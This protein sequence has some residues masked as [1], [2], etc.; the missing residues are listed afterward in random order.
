MKNITFTILFALLYFITGE[1]SFTL[2]TTTSFE[3]LSIFIP[4][5]VALASIMLFGRKVVGG[6]FL[7]QVLLSLSSG[8]TFFTTVAIATTN[9]LEAFIAF[10]LIRRFK[11]KITPEDL[12]GIYKLFALILFILQPFS[13]FFATL[14]LY[15]GDVVSSS[16]IFDTAFTWWF[17]N[18]MGQILLTPT[19]VIL[20]KSIEAKVLNFQYIVQNLFILIVIYFFIYSIPVHN[21]ALLM[22]LTLPFIMLLVTHYGIVY[23][24]ITVFFISFISLAESKLGIGIFNG[25][26]TIDFIN[27]NFFIIA[28][29]AITYTYGILHMQKEKAFNELDL[30][31]KNLEKKIANEVLKSREKD[32]FV[33]YQSRL[34]QMGE[35]INMI[36]HQWRQPLNTVSIMNQ[37]IVFKYKKNKLDDAYIE[38]FST[39]ST[40]QIEYMS[41]TINDF[42]D[43]FKPE[44][45]K[46]IFTLNSSVLHILSIIQKVFEKDN[47]TLNFNEKSKDSIV[48]GYPNEFSQALL[49][50]LN[51]A[52]D[53]LLEKSQEKKNITITLDLIEEDYTL[54]VVDNAGGIDIDI[55]ERIFEPY[56]ST[57]NDHN[58]TGLGLHMARMIIEEHMHGSL[59]VQNRDDG[60][61]F[62][63]RI[64]KSK[65]N[66]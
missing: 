35:I 27:I 37:S 25:H 8:L 45:E 52:K 3:T 1:I 34:A 43:F 23:G 60:A 47:I 20:H 36:A 9:A 51:N 16:D 40:K 2:E 42:R 14:W 17:G 38:D 4:E 58:G 18:V 64:K 28:H 19:L 61:E 54:S 21:M 55:I 15:I 49:S 56:F 39:T 59:H 11:I 24:S 62:L 7:G 66:I 32:K 46:E 33:L 22:S 31:N 6:I 44:K 5:G 10:H 30:L 53:A 41:K 65:E 26:D 48:K 12:S 63:I 13:S 50:I 29:I 57:K